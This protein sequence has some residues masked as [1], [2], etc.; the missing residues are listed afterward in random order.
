M[1]Q[2]MRQTPRMDH[3]RDP[4]PETSTRA[5]TRIETG[6]H[7]H[8][9]IETGI[10]ADDGIEYDDLEAPEMEDLLDQDDLFDYEDPLD[11]RDDFTR[12]PPPDELAPAEQQ[13]WTLWLRAH[14]L[15]EARFTQA[16]AGSAGISLP[17]ATVLLLVGHY[18][19]RR[20]RVQIVEITG[21]SESRTSH[22]L[23]RMERD[24]LVNTV[25]DW[26]GTMIELTRHGWEVHHQVRPEHS[27]VLRSSLL[28]P[29][30]RSGH[31][32]T[33]ALAAIVDRL[34][35]VYPSEW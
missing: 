22:L 4:N 21:W 28:W 13:A 10:G 3:R 25:R 33:P 7:P 26:C 19:G 34:D 5:H 12:R 16:C 35:P 29:I 14:A 32:L 8:T 27:E 2:M 20:R 18:G 11:V 6:A 23:R 24:D 30:E 31:R 17:E 1:R 9:G 15:L